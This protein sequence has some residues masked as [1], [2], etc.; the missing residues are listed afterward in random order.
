[1]NSNS[2]VRGF[3]GFD[4]G[5]LATY[6]CPA[7]LFFN[8]CRA[9]EDSRHETRH[10]QWRAGWT[11]AT[12][13]AGHQPQCDSDFERYPDWHVDLARAA[14]RDHVLWIL[15]RD[16]RH[17]FLFRPRSGG[18]ETANLRD[19]NATRGRQLQTDDPTAPPCDPD[20]K[21]DSSSQAAAAW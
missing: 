5:S 18:P 3:A 21:A 11:A 7:S 6:G 16:H 17:D 20:S 1:M 2:W 13:P 14:D 12:R 15:C 10:H 8:I 9:V 19:P 4:D